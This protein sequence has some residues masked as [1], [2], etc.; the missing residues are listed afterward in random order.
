MLA[1]KANQVLPVKWHSRIMEFT[2]PSESCQVSFGTSHFS[3]S[4][5]SLHHGCV[6][7]NVR[8][9]ALPNKFLK[10]FLA[11]PTWSR[12]IGVEP[13]QWQKWEQRTHDDAIRLRGGSVAAWSAYGE[14]FSGLGS[15]GRYCICK[16]EEHSSQDASAKSARPALA[17]ASNKAVYMTTS[18]RIPAS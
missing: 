8:G 4:C 12:M 1:Y 14:V 13:N 17:A 16:N 15:T 7:D 9:K 6:T 5:M 18:A 2:S 10:P 3:S 11:A